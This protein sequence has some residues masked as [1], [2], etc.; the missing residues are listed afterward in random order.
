MVKLY[1]NLK[2]LFASF[3]III[4]L[5]FCCT[6][7]ENTSSRS[8]VIPEAKPLEKIFDF[9]RYIDHIEYIPLQDT[10]FLEGV[11]RIYFCDDLMIIRD[12]KNRSD[13]IHFFDLEG[14]Y[15][16]SDNHILEGYPP[17]D[18]FGMTSL[19]DFALDCPNKTL[20]L[21]DISRNHIVEYHIPTRTK[22]RKFDNIRGQALH[23]KDSL[24]YVLTIDKEDGMLKLYNT[25]TN[26][27]VGEF[28]YDEKQDVGGGSTSSQMVNVEDGVVISLLNSDTIYKVV[29]NICEPYIALGNDENTS[30][31]YFHF[32]DVLQSYS[33]NKNDKF[34]QLM[35][36]MG[37]ITSIE[38]LLVLPMM[39][40]RVLFIDMQNGKAYSLHREFISGRNLLFSFSTYI[41][42]GV[43]HHDGLYHGSIKLS[44][45]FYKHAK[46]II[47]EEPDHP[48]RQAL[49]AF[50]DEY[51]PERNFQNPVITR[52]KISDDF[53]E[54]FR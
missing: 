34:P 11:S 17:S 30:A 25:Y 16:Y 29:Q 1:D 13:R 15:L 52:F 24:L 9:T 43:G 45:S 49:S 8:L 31:R 6:Q 4:F 54:A 2:V 5:L 53:M 22:L 47:H 14:N 28:I 50:L 26:E 12:Q 42:Y 32:M 33:G 19:P 36:P 38:G 40:R 20:Y 27:K 46:Q 37:E 44:N 18:P 10:I 39:N 7:Q 23:H 41:F 21:S 35:I 48:L 3:G 51:P